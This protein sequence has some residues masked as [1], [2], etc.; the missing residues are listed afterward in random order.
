MPTPLGPVPPAPPM[1]PR[2]TWRDAAKCPCGQ[3]P[4][5]CRSHSCYDVPGREGATMVDHSGQIPLEGLE[6]EPSII[7]FPMPSASWGN[8]QAKVLG[9]GDLLNLTIDRSEYE[10]YQIAP[11]PVYVGHWM[12]GGPGGLRIALEE[13][14]AWV[15]RKL[16][17][18]L[19]NWRWVDTQP[20]P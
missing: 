12:I 20:F 14:P 5:W 3:S 16:C 6:P 7:N 8:W 2:A 11:E 19:L 18:F 17:R 9:P 10:G 15:V 13:R 1:P 4:D